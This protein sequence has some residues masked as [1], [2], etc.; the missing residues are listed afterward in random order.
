[1]GRV[2]QTSFHFGTASKICEQIKGGEAG[3]RE[4][5][6]KTTWCLFAFWIG[7]LCFWGD[8]NFSTYFY[9]LSTL[10]LLLKFLLNTSYRAL[11]VTWCWGLDA[12]QLHLSYSLRIFPAQQSH[13]AESPAQSPRYF[14]ACKLSFLGKPPCCFSYHHWGMDVLKDSERTMKSLT[15][16]F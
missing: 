8:V 7:S 3:R 13:I 12:G 1:M 9:L 11:G 5:E 16:G 6:V 15:Q 2:V 10:P 4:K 14:L